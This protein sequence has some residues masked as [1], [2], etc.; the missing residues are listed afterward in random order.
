MKKKKVEAYHAESTRIERKRFDFEFVQNRKK[1]RRT[2]MT[3]RSF[4]RSF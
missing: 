1:I 3:I 2:I 4:D